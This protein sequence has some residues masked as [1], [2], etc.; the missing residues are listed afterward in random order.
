ML[1][2]I[3]QWYPIYGTIVIMSRLPK[4]MSCW[5]LSAFK[6]P[7]CG[8]WGRNP[9]KMFIVRKKS[10]SGFGMIG[11]LS[12]FPARMSSIGLKARRNG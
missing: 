11:L 10:E 2:K 1:H 12:I 7:F 8:D 9:G 4:F 3:A 6:L 5:Y